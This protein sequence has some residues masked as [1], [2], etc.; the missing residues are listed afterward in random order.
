MYK[1]G[2][3]TDPGNHRP[4]SVLPSISK[5]SERFIADRIVEHVA[6]N[7]LI[8]V[9]QSRFRRNHGTH[10]ALHSPCLNHDAICNSMER[11]GIRDCKVL[12][13][14]V[15]YRKQYVSCNGFESPSERI[16]NGVP[17][18]SIPGPLIFI[19]TICDIENVIKACLH[20]FAD[21]ITTWVMV[22]NASSTGRNCP[23]VIHLPCFQRSVYKLRLTIYPLGI[24]DTKNPVQT[25]YP[26]GIYIIIYDIWS[27]Y[28]TTLCLH[29]EAK[30]LTLIWRV[31][32]RENI[33]EFLTECIRFGHVHTR[34]SSHN[35]HLTRGVGITKQIRITYT[36]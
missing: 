28:K 36:K 29:R 34:C 9:H 14:Y 33:P 21:D 25:I 7:H 6:E 12:N 24:Y 19:L 27:W 11:I 10:L 35:V 22:R 4:V 26:S 15:T 18:G 8:N 3:K 2:V 20:L 16:M 13:D 17:Q 30:L 31:L 5:I 1:K 32:K 23:R